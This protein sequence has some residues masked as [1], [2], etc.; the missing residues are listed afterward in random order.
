MNR[1]LQAPSWTSHGP[2]DQS[3]LSVSVICLK[4]IIVGRWPLHPAFEDLPSFVASRFCTKLETCVIEDEWTRC[5]VPSEEQLLSW[6][7]PGSHQ[8]EQRGRLEWCR[9]HRKGLSCVS[10]LHRPRELSGT[11]CRSLSEA[12][13]VAVINFHPMP[14]HDSLAGFYRV[15]VR[16]THKELAIDTCIADRTWSE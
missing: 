9:C 5:S 15:S 1:E 13:T 12:T 14:L 6:S 11:W 2:S 16:H 4:R 3:N 10:V 8:R 7:I